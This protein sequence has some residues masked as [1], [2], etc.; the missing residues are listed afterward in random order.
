MRARDVTLPGPDAED[1]WVRALIHKATLQLGKQ[2]IAGSGSG[3][4]IRRARRSAGKAHEVARRIPPAQVGRMGWEQRAGAA[5]HLRP[6]RRGRLHDV[7]R[8]LEAA[9]DLPEP[10]GAG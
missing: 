5:G 7:K 6:V 9:G 4:V 2:W 10:P 3:S 1:Q 8:R